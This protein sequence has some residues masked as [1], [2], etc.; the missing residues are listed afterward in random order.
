MR[1]ASTAFGRGVGSKM[2]THIIAEAKSRGMTRLSL[3]TGENEA[4]CAC[5]GAL[6]Q[7]WL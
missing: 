4:S 7:I 2:L 6:C 1:T 3:E 5:A